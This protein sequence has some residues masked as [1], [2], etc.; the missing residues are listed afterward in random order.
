MVILLVFPQNFSPVIPF[1]SVSGF[2]PFLAI[3]TVRAGG[4][5]PKSL[6]PFKR[7]SPNSFHFSLPFFFPFFW[8]I[9]R[10][11]GPGVLAMQP[12][13]YSLHPLIQNS[14]ISLFA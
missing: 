1:V 7:F 11:A 9:S 10:R 5:F 3:Q 13:E 14:I 6:G 8:W 4:V 12:G 2:D